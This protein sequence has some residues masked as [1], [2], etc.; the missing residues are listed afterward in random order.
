MASLLPW[1]VPVKIGNPFHGQIYAGA[2][3]LPNGSTRPWSYGLVAGFTPIKL[4]A[5]DAP[6]ASTPEAETEAGREWRNYL[7]YQAGGNDPYAEPD[8]ELA[9][10]PATNGFKAVWLY[11]P[12]FGLTFRMRLSKAGDD[13]TLHAKQVGLLNA[14]IGLGEQ[15][16]WSATVTTHYFNFADV[17]DGAGDRVLL[18]TVHK[19]SGIN[20][21]V[22]EWTLAF[23]EETNIVSITEGVIDAVPSSSTSDTDVTKIRRTS[24]EDVTIQI[25][26]YICNNGVTEIEVP[27]YQTVR[28]SILVPLDDPVPYETVSTLSGN[29]E[30]ENTIHTAS[31]NELIWAIY[32]EGIG[33][34]IRMT[35]ETLNVSESTVTWTIEGERHDEEATPCGSVNTITDVPFIHQ[36]LYTT[37]VDN[38]TTSELIVGG[39][40]VASTSYSLITHFEEFYPSGAIELLDPSGGP[41]GGWDV[42]SESETGSFMDISIR[43][44]THPLIGIRTG[45]GDA[46][47]IL[48]TFGISDADRMKTQSLNH[49]AA[50]ISE[51]DFVHS[52]I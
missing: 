32:Q 7:L 10:A 9:F 51:E 27:L 21:S 31:A 40:A 46:I 19:V 45:P 52:W 26:S 17:I 47:E 44:R 2:V 3:H 33:K 39:V 12:R 34:S 11:T 42:E 43:A 20:L 6:A 24:Y 38:A 49:V 1:Q 8:L 16:V 30:I 13:Y 36:V 4:Q 50:D 28:N 18:M 15:L 37:G 29:P 35:T 5:S 22:I 14:G 25:G 41:V 23:N 48:H